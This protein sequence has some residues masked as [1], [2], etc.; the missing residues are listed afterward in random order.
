MDVVP[1]SKER[2]AR[3]GER[4][5]NPLPES[6]T[7]DALQPTVGVG[8]L[9]KTLRNLVQVDVISWTCLRVSVIPFQQAFSCIPAASAYV[10]LRSLL[11]P[12]KTLA[13]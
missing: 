8:L 6:Q 4:W 10:L 3:N 7:A 12:T 2:F 9:R 1:R 13:R 11:R 5:I